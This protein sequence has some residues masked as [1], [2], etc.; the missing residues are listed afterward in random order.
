LVENKKN[1]TLQRLPVF[2]CYPEMKEGN[3]TTAAVAAEFGCT[4]NIQDYLKSTNRSFT[5]D[6]WMVKTAGA[7]RWPAIAMRNTRA[8][9][10]LQNDVGTLEIHCPVAD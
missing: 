4:P 6:W 5:P 9:R 1:T 8:V 7:S 10:P 2:R 3:G